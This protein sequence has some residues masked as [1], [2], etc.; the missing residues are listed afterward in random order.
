[1]IVKAKDSLTADRI[2]ERINDIL[3]EGFDDFA[4]PHDTHI[5]K[6]M[7]DIFYISK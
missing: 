1:M 6:E 7:S 5:D 4:E 2:L 3:T